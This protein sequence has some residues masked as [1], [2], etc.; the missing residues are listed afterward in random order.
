VRS[1]QDSIQDDRNG[2]SCVTQAELKKT[3]DELDSLKDAFEELKFLFE[4]A[5]PMLQ[6]SD[7]HRFL[8][9]SYASRNAVKKVR[10][11]VRVLEDEFGPLTERTKDLELEMAAVKFNTADNEK[12]LADISKDLTD[13][14]KRTEEDLA[15]HEHRL[16]VMEQQFAAIEHINLAKQVKR[17]GI[18]ESKVSCIVDETA[19]PDSFI[20]EKCDLVVRNGEG[21]TDASPNGKGNIIVGYN[22]WNSD[23]GSQPSDKNGSHNL[24]VGPGH[25]YTS[26]GSILGGRDNFSQGPSTS[27]VGGKGNIANAEY[28]SVAGGFRNYASEVYSSVGGGS[29]NTASGVYSFAVGGRQNTASGVYSSVTGGDRNAAVGDYSSVTGGSE[30]VAHGKYSSITGGYDNHANGQSSIV[31]GGLFNNAT[32]SHSTVTGGRELIATKMAENLP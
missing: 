10:K 12:K 18:V 25:T 32:G 4:M 30:S 21:K 23:R 27:I 6:T 29:G 15:F 19:T 28:A 22:E 20:V 17:L 1:E 26:Y 31:T 11:R 2:K 7:K 9:D 14:A 13:H 8:Q 3:V 16:G 24:I 5:G